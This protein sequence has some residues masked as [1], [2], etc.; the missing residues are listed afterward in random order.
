MYCLDGID[1]E[2]QEHEVGLR[3]FAGSQEV[4]TGVGGHAPVIMLAAAVDAGE[5]L[6]MEQD[7]QLVT[8]GDAVHDIHQENVVIDGYA[9][10]F[11]DGGALELGGATSLWRVRRGIPSL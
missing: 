1:E 4:D 10:F 9:D 7:P 6:F 3:R 11:E 2:G 8:A 5:R